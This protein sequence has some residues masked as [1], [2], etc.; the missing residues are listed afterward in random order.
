MIHKPTLEGLEDHLAGR[1]GAPSLERFHSH[2]AQCLECREMVARME[3]QSGLVR[4]LRAPEETLPARGFYAR[5]MNR[6][7]QQ[8]AGSFW[9]VLLE[10]VFGR[11]LMYASLALF[12]LLGTAAVSF[13]TGG[14]VQ[15]LPAEMIAQTDLPPTMDL[16]QQESRQVVL[17]NLATYDGGAL[18]GGVDVLPTAS[19]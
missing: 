7:E 5:V 19:Q 4:S 9:S 11:R 15:A 6:I 18:G 16:D 10:P 8:S 12:L 2:L 17:V 14:L 13:H 1:A 3:A